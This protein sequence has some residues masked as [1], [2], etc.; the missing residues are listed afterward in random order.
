MKQLGAADR[1][2]QAH[3]LLH[4]L[5]TLAPNNI[6]VW[7]AVYDVAI[8]RSKLSLNNLRLFIIFNHDFPGKLLQAVAALNR[9]SGLNRDHAELHIRLI[10]LKQTGKLVFDHDLAYN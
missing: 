8:R 3:K 7:I 9:A 1:L 5:C 2:D 4:P 6:D 10:D